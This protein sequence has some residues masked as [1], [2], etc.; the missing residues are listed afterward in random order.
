MSAGS[1]VSLSLTT[2]SDDGQ[3]IDIFGNVLAYPAPLTIPA[4]ANMVQFLYADT[5]AGMPTLTASAAN[6]APATQAETIVAD[7]A[8]QLAFTTPEQALTAGTASSTITVAL[9]DD[10]G[11]PVSASSALPVTLGTSSPNGSFVP[12]SPL[13]IPVGADTA[14][15]QYTDTA[16]GMPTLTVAA[17]G[18][19]SASQEETVNPAAASRIIF[20]ST[21]QT[22]TAG[23]A[24]SPITVV[25]EDSFGNPVN[26]ASPLTVNLS[27]TSSAGTFTPVSPLTIPAG[28]GIGV[29]QYSD[30]A[31]GAPTITVGATGLASATQQESVS[32][33]L[34]SRLEFTTAPQTFTAGGTSDT[35]T[36]ALQDAFGNAVSASG[37]LTINLTTTSPSGVFSLTS[38]VIIPAGAGMVSFQYSDTAAGTPTLTVAAGGLASA[39]QMET[40]NSAVASRLV[41]TTPSQNL[42]AGV[43]SGT[44]TVML[45]DASGNTVNASSPLTVDLSTTSA[46]GTFTP[47]SPLTIPAGAN[48]LSFQ[49]TDTAAGTPALSVAASGLASATQ[50][51]TVNAAA[52]SHL[53]FT[54]APQT[55]TAGIASGTITIALEDAFGNAVDA[56]SPLTV[57]LSTNSAAGTFTPVSPLT[58]PAGT[59]IVSFKYTDTAAGSPTLTVAASGLASATQTETVN[60]A[61]ASHLAFTTAPQT[62]TAGVASGTITIALEDTF[63]N[64]V[65]AGSPLTVNLSTTSAAGTFTPV[66]PLTIPAGT[67]IV[68]FKYTDTAAGSPTITVAASGLASATQTETVNAAAASHLAFTTPPQTLTAG[69]ASGTITIALE[70]AFGNTVNASSPLTVNLS[71]TSAA[72]TFTPVSPVTIPAGTG[73]VSFK[74]TDSAAGS[75]TI[76]VAASGLASASQSESVNA[77]AASHLAFT[78][79]PQT[80]TAGVASGTIT[81]ALEDAFGNAVNASSP[82]TVNLSTTSTA[83]T[84]TPASP[85]TIPAGVAIVTF[86]YSDTVAGTPTLTAAAGGLASAAQQETVNPAAVGH[87]AFTTSPQILT[88]GAVSGTITIAEEDAFG[89]QVNANSPLTVSLST[90]SSKGV[91]TPISPLIIPAGTSTVGFTYMDTAAGLDTLTATAGSLPSASQQETVNPAAASRL[92]FTT[93]AQTLAAGVTSSTI[94]VSLQDTFGNAVNASSPLTVNLSTT[95][96]KGEFTPASPLTISAGASS[97]N[98]NYTDT[99]AGAPT[100]TAAASSFAAATQQENVNPA[101]AS[102]LVFTTSPQTL[103]AG[104]A[105]GTITVALEDAFGNAVNAASAV[106]V[107]MKSSSAGG[108]FLPASPVT[109]AAGAHSADFAYTDTKAGTHAYRVCQWPGLGHTTGD[110]GCRGRQSSGI[111][112]A[113]SDDHRRRCLRVDHSCLDGQFR[114]PGQGKQRFARHSWLDLKRRHVHAEV[115]AYDRGRRQRGKFHLLGHQ[116]RNAY[117]Y[118]LRRQSDC[119]HTEVYRN[120]PG[121][122]VA[123]RLRLC[124]CQ[125]QR[126]ADGL[127]GPVQGR[128]SQRHDYA[129]AHPTPPLPIRRRSRKAT[130]PT[131]SARCPPAL[132]PRRDP[133]ATIPQRRKRHSRQPRR[134][135][136]HQRHHQPDRS[137]RQPKRHGIRLRRVASAPGSLSKRLTLASLP[138]YGCFAG[139][140]SAGGRHAGLDRLAGSPSRQRRP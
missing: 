48:M 139:N 64:A 135:R 25:V 83:G 71:T 72:G 113:A 134:A 98:F 61:A 41:F 33:A 35:I 102:Q 95:S 120:R 42:T 19:A 32:P 114:Q 99:A 79:A 36:V 91:F 93:A 78:T 34:A 24:S 2:T 88:A 131:S 140:C 126:P 6:L 15:F 30:T 128:N 105:S 62:L 37:D 56:G 133:T 85:L 112:L 40:V 5:L 111:Y 138:C 74:Y 127:L 130:A 3:F 137:E 65:D 7:A 129:Q 57:N 106:T 60:A 86:K 119:R 75:P 26:A 68:S 59:G 66:S 123:L 96:A 28:A 103:T 115:T 53:A 117:G 121:Q 80:L 89:N 50:T 109:V 122:R 4:G 52:A 39:S 46:T 124:G 84:F 104:I 29:F 58:I 45:E 10:F 136:I 108:S 8:S 14:S 49:Y 12:L 21:P 101:A 22:L 81:I 1:S 77:A 43:A 92:A 97:V 13:T 54:T 11:N 23:V 31:A 27:T 67:G 38:P 63:G 51:E 125:Q 9:E 76:K 82:L 107:S 118:R 69:V 20:M 16:A 100:L 17:G 110:G 90:T 47:V 116:A 132:H 55:L 73:I 87:L 70:D 94:T 18:F 44:I